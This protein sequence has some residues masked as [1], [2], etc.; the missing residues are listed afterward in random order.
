MVS[1]GEIVLTDFPYTDLSSSKLRPALV[2][3]TDNNN[4]MLAF[5]TSQFPIEKYDV[6]IKPTTQNGLRL[7][8]LI[9][10]SKVMT[11][12]QKRIVGRIGELDQQTFDHVRDK[13][14][15]IFEL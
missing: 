12:D 15:L 5:I 7:T 13:L 2:L 8:S 9:R 1:R 6:E 10:L 4:I 14:R 3:L 11:L